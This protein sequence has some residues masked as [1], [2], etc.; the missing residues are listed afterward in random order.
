MAA[1]KVTF[2]LDPATVA[3]IEDASARLSMPKSQVVREAIHE[4][5]ER[6]GRLSHSERLRM[7]RALDQLAPRVPARSRREVDRE[8][9]ALRRDRRTGGRRSLAVRGKA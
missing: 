1:T 7:L 3:R 9:S 2:T 4:F 5:H 6:I 8:L